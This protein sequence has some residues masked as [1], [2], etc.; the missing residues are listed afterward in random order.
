MPTAQCAHVDKWT[1]LQLQ[2]FRG[3]AF[4][5]CSFRAAIMRGAS[6][7]IRRALRVLCR[8][9]EYLRVLSRYLSDSRTNTPGHEDCDVVVVGGGPAGLALASA[10]GAY[11]LGY[12]KHPKRLTRLYTLSASKKTLRGSVKVTLVEGGDLS[13][14]YNWDLPPDAFSNRVVSLT[15]STLDFLDGVSRPFFWLQLRC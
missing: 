15:N 14:I 2:L 4:P 6:S 3:P 5:V 8:R 11:P 10:L 9:R 12:P 7:N 13:K 1:G